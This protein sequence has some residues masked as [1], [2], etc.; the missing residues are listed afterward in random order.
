[1]TRATAQTLGYRALRWEASE[2]GNP[3]VLL[4]KFDRKTL[5]A[6]LDAATG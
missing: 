6:A 1:M 5:R 2:E 4:G 3:F